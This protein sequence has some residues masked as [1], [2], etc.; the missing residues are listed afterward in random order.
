[1][2]K[3][4][5]TAAILALVASP[6]MAWET[7]DSANAQWQ[8]QNISAAGG[9]GY[10][11]S[12]YTSG[13]YGLGGS[14]WNGAEGQNQNEGI[15]GSYSYAGST[16][17]W[18]LDS[19]TGGGSSFGLHFEG[20]YTDAQAVGAHNGYGSAGYAGSAIQSD[21]WAMS[22]GDAGSYSYTK[23]YVAYKTVNNWY[24]AGQEFDGYSYVNTGAASNGWGYSGVESATSGGSAAVNSG[25]QSTSMAAGSASHSEINAWGNAGGE[26]GNYNHY[27][28]ATGNGLTYQN[29]E[30]FTAT[31]VS[32]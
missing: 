21:R 19:G 23:G 26:T 20:G 32:E 8:T 27:A 4:L 6:A 7:G 9:P 30:G 25:W 15:H 1:M 3:A 12:S 31:Q 18:D 10:L 28:Q 11:S 22:F 29:Q 14:D 16:H 13:Q 17:S 24:G 2:R 5:L